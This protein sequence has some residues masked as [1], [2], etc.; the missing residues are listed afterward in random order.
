LHKNLKNH[1]FK[2]LLFIGSTVQRKDLEAISTV[3][4]LLHTSG[5]RGNSWMESKVM[6]SWGHQKAEWY[7]SSFTF[8]TGKGDPPPQIRRKQTSDTH[9]KIRLLLQLPCLS[10]PSS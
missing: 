7:T 6:R 9:C 2:S 1:D 5:S 8:S 10:F 3:R 4:R